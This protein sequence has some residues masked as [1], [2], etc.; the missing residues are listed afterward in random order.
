MISEIIRI[1]TFETTLSSWIL[2]FSYLSYR[3]KKQQKT[4]PSLKLTLKWIAGR[5]SFP[6]GARLSG[7]CKLLVLGRVNV[8]TSPQKKLVNS[9]WGIP[10]HRK[11]NEHINK[12]YKRRMISVNITRTCLKTSGTHTTSVGHIHEEF[13][14][15]FPAASWAPD[16]CFSNLIVLLPGTWWSSIY[17]WLIMVLSIGWWS[18]K[19]LHRKWWAAYC[20]HHQITKHPSIH[21]SIKKYLFKVPGTEASPLKEWM[22]KFVRRSGDCWCRHG[23]KGSPLYF[24]TKCTVYF[25]ISMDFW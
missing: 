1:W 20:S 7:R 8:S 10:H 17:K 22:S 13:F 19:S 5:R 23:G 6:F 12:P 18:T 16:P 9:W 24:P 15:I 25:Q 21:P 4:L 11:G 3:N 2:N 14:R